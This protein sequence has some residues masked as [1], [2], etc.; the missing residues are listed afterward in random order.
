MP[1]SLSKYSKHEEQLQNHMTIYKASHKLL[2]SATASKALFLDDMQTFAGL[3]VLVT[4]Q[5]FA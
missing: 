4:L 2:V 1:L 5:T 3:N